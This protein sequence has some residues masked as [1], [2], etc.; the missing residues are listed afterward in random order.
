MLAEATLS[1]FWS[2]K[3]P[4]FL[5]EQS[6]FSELT[7]YWSTHIPLGPFS[8]DPCS[9]TLVGKSLVGA[10]VTVICSEEA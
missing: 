10:G 7:H 4:G 3:R 1:L 2:R 9:L 5:L 6:D 8:H